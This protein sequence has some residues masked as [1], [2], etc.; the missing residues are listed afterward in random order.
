[1]MYHCK[2]CGHNFNMDYEE[3]Y[4]PVCGK[5]CIVLW[6]EQKEWNKQESHHIWPMFMDNPDGKGQ[7]FLVWEK[8]HR[9]LHG[10]I[11]KWIWEEICEEKKREVIDTIIRKSKS[12]LDKNK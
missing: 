9:V 4:C 6:P 5:S 7:Q 1:M 12:F 10:L 2:Y 11:M 8:N 3:E